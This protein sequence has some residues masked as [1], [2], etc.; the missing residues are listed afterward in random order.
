MIR[1]LAALAA[2]LL[3]ISTGSGFLFGQVQRGAIEVKTVDAQGAQFP[4]GCQPPE[5]WGPGSSGSV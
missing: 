2:V 1:R 4:T 3:V 5:D